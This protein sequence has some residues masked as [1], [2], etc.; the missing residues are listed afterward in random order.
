MLDFKKTYT[1][2]NGARAALLVSAAA[3]TFFLVTPSANAAGLAGL[4]DVVENVTDKVG[5]GDVGK[6]VDD[7]VDNVADTVDSVGDG[8]GGVVDTVTGQSGSNSLGSGTDDVVDG[9]ASILGG[10]GNSDGDSVTGNA[11]D[12][13][14]SVGDLLGG[15]VD[16]VLGQEGD[17]TLGGGLDD[18]VDSVGSIL[19]G[20]DGETPPQN[21]EGDDCPPSSGCE[22]GE[23]DCTNGGDDDDPNADDDSDYGG[24]VFGNLFG[25]ASTCK[26]YGNSE[27]Y[28]GLRAVDKNSML[29]GRIV[30]VELSNDLKIVS[31]RL[32]TSSRVFGSNRCIDI[33]GGTIT[34]ANG[35]VILPVDQARI[36]ESISRN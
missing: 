26:A 15:T 25:G 30:G 24:G 13:V 8:V 9:V 20:P 22:E 2:K 11:A 7:V 33:R 21:C 18:V 36:I 3:L 4:G 6:G 23:D 32:E 34:A 28:T 16:D 29:L 10:T 31:V 35:A 5:L 27:S 12:T 19:D 1:M 14:D 17:D